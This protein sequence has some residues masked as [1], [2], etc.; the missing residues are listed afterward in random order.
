MPTRSSALATAATCGSPCSCLE[1]YITT[2]TYPF[3]CV[4]ALPTNNASCTRCNYGATGAGSIAAPSARVHT[5]RRAPGGHLSSVSTP[6]L[7]VVFHLGWHHRWIALSPPSRML[8]EGIG[9]D[10]LIAAASSATCTM[11]SS[12]WSPRSCQGFFLALRIACIGGLEWVGGSLRVD[13]PPLP[14][15]GMPCADRWF[16]AGQTHCFLLR[17]RAISHSIAQKSGIGT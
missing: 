2:C 12:C 5:T 1:P 16:V 14:P 9:A 6:R 8:V 7:G 10:L 15:R 4:L 11:F 13:P 3:D 17:V